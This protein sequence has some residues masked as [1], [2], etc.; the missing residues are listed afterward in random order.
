MNLHN[1]PGAYLELIQATATD[2]SI[3]AIYVEKDYWVT[4]VLKRLAESEYREAIVF[5]GGTSLSKAHR[6]IERFSEDID[7]ALRGGHGLGD[8]PA[9]STVTDFARFL[10]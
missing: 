4:H 9:C 6:L 3:P 8:R 2:S 7:L 5:K 10:G 1:S